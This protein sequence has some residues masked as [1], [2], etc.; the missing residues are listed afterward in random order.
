MCI[1]ASFK[2]RPRTH[3]LDF[4]GTYPTSSKGQ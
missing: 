2:S 3:K 4:I 1:I